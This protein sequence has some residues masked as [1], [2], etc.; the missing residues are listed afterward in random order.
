MEQSN[1]EFSVARFIVEKTNHNLFLTGKAGSG[2]TTFLKEIVSHT[3]KKHVVLAPTGAAAINAGAMTIHSFFQ[4]GFGPYLPGV[5]VPEKSFSIKKSKLELIKALELII[6]DEISMVRADMLDQIDAELRRIRSSSEP[7]G[8]VQMLMI[9]DLQQLPPIAKENDRILLERAYPSFHFFECKALRNTDYYFIELKK[10]YRQNDQ[11]FIDI[12]N[13]ARTNKV[14]NSD[15]RDLNARYIPNFCPQ[16]T[17]KYIRLVTHN[18]Q[19]ES[20]NAVEMAKLDGESFIFD[21]QVSGSFS[22][23]SFPTYRHLELKSGAQVMFVRNDSNPE[24]RY[25]NGT[26]AEVSHVNKD[27]VTVRLSSGEEVDLERVEWESIRYTYDEQNKKIE[28]KSDG[29][30]QQ[31]PVKPAWAITVHKS[32]GLTFDRAI[33]DV[34][35]AF[36]P[37]QAYVALSR[38]RSLDGIVLSAKLSPA[39]F[40]TD[41]AVESYLS[42]VSRD[43]DSLARLVEYSPFTYEDQQQP[44]S[45]LL[46]ALKEWRKALAKE[47]CIPA[48][49][50]ASDATLQEIA[51]SVPISPED[52]LKI[53]GMGKQ[54]VD[55]YGKAILDLV[56]TST[57][58]RSEL[59]EETAGAVRRERIPTRQI[60]YEMFMQGMDIAQIAKERSLVEGT[61]LNHLL[62]YIESGA[63]DVSRLVDDIA[64]RKVRGFLR[65]HTGEYSLRDIYEYCNGTISYDDLKI[66]L[67]FING[68][69]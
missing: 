57:L 20:I 28:A 36:S 18:G 58:N 13:R 39:V 23:D 45:S 65:R 30:F 25:I 41:S 46:D 24:R 66:A 50:I 53:R 27:G 22:E 42:G 2:K 56:A 4:F 6:I 40:I 44:D 38:C 67:A 5:S 43:I 14:T 47:R 69:H 11:H 17:D 68:A 31:F 60:T 63:V 21:A 55:N 59:K 26:I 16:K 15:I 12:L 33:I 37:G 10:V 51:A 19:V 29:K 62:P 9:G 35:A 34:H 8:G 7:F 64:L 61:V 54:R 1:F 3:R 52:L 32:Q 48:Y 49:A